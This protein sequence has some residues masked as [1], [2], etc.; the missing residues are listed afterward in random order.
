MGNLT[1]RLDFRTIPDDSEKSSLTLLP[2]RV[3]TGGEAG[4]FLD[5]AIADLQRSD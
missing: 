3:V 5:A 4:R 1:V 2:S